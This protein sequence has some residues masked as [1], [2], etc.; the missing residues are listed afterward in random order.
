MCDWYWCV[1]YSMLECTRMKTMEEWTEHWRAWWLLILILVKFRIAEFVFVIFHHIVEHHYTLS[2]TRYSH[3]AEGVRLSWP[4]LFRNQ[5]TLWHFKPR[6]TAT[7]GLLLLMFFD[8][9]VCSCL[10]VCVSVGHNCELWNNWDGIC[11][12]DSGEPKEPCIRCGPDPRWEGVVFAG[13]PLRCGLSSKF[14]VDLLLFALHKFTSLLT[15]WTK[16]CRALCCVSDGTR[17]HQ[18]N[19]VDRSLKVSTHWRR[20]PTECW[21]PYRPDC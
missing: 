21:P 17:C 12:V 3:C 15:M 11:D 9:R 14:S 1:L 4:N 6:R 5:S 13:I 2:S 18:C 19:A 8:P 20:T 10:C 16:R 7:C